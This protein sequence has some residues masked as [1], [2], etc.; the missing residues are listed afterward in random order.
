MALLSSCGTP[1]ILA[2][3]FFQLGDDCTFEKSDTRAG[4]V[5]VMVL[6]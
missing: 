2:I 5:C 4:D 1:L 6:V 3:W